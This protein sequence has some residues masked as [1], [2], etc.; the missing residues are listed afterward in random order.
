MSKSDKF[1][2]SKGF[3]T[4]FEHL[5]SITQADARFTT[6]YREISHTQDINWG[7]NNAS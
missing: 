7:L 2:F 6:L 3:R 5:R 1:G 4:V